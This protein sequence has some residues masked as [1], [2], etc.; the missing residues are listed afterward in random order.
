MPKP[1]TKV[2]NT[3]SEIDDDLIAAVGGFPIVVKT[4]LE[5][6]GKGVEILRTEEDYVRR[7]G[8]CAQY[9]FAPLIVQSFIPGIDID[10]SFI[11][12]DGEAMFIESQIADSGEIALIEC[13]ARFW[14]SEPVLEHGTQCR[15]N[16]PGLRS[17]RSSRRIPA[18]TGKPC[19]QHAGSA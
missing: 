5:G 11:A 2:V 12:L 16:R 6:G 18:V 9:Q 10:A 15:R 17:E 14:G 7:V 19:L 8:S 13:N 4:A 1:A 3:K